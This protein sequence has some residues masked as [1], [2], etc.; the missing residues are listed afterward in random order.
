[1]KE[2][3]TALSIV[4]YYLSEYSKLALQALG[5]STYSSA[6]KH[7]SLLF[8]RDN[9][10][11]KLRRDEFDALP[12]SSSVRKG[13]RNRP[14]AKEVI[15]MA[16]YLKKFTFDELTGLVRALIDAQSAPK[17]DVPNDPEISETDIF[18][19]TQ[20]EDIINFEDHLSGIRVKFGSK[21]IR[22]YNSSIIHNLK[23]LYNGC[24]QLCG[25][26]PF[27]T[28]GCNLT[29]VHHIDY[30][31]H[32]HNNNASNLVVVCPNHHRLIHK[33]NPQFDPQNKC[34]IYPNGM[35]EDIKLNYHL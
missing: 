33:L 10:Y 34:F 23:L 27:S 28:F 2:G 3:S 4:A 12:D 8:D 26:R 9:N 30:F 32:S 18:S 21:T 6:F 13:W 22:I 29:E 11:L 15:E 16:A 24:C 20:L 35:K 5:Y 14:A 19:E 1:M 31:M 25:E 7:I 17:N